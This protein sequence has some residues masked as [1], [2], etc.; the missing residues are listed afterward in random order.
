[1]ADADTTRGA[2]FWLGM[3]AS[4]CR[5]KLNV[6]QYKSEHD[7]AVK[8]VE[9]LLGSEA[10][11]AFF[12]NMKKGLSGAA[13]MPEAQLKAGLLGVAKYCAKLAV[14]YDAATMQVIPLHPEIIDMILAE[15]EDTYNPDKNSVTWHYRIHSGTS[16]TALVIFFRKYT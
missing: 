1:M 10:T 14:S 4:F 7:L 13:L 3:A 16:R 6:A 12:G 11:E 8:A 5:A 2:R 9:K 15:L